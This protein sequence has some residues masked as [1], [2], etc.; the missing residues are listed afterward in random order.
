MLFAAWSG[1]LA[2]DLALLQAVKRDYPKGAY[3]NRIAFP[4]ASFGLV[5]R[6][7]CRSTWTTSKGIAC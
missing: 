4:M 5:L 1:S 7:L 2:T 3:L 6:G